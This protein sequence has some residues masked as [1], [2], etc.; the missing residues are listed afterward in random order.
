MTGRGCVRWRG[1]NATAGYWLSNIAGKQV[2]LTS[3]NRCFVP[4]TSR[5][6]PRGSRRGSDP[7]MDVSRSNSSGHRQSADYPD[8]PRRRNAGP[9]SAYAAMV[10][11]WMPTNSV[12]APERPRLR[13]TGQPL[14]GWVERMGRA[15]FGMPGRSGRPTSTS[16]DLPHRNLLGAWFY[17]TG[18]N[19]WNRCLRCVSN[20]MKAP[21]IEV[22]YG[23]LPPSFPGFFRS[24]YALSKNV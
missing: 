4:A 23:W 18:E 20:S 1:P 24:A 14:R 3:L 8:A 10:T 22:K 19:T 5:M 2:G 16:R 11:G 9:S 13:G 17:C 15:N 21:E 7:A 6:V 12:P